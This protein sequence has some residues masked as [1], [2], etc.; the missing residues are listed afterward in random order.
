MFCKTLFCVSAC[1]LL[2]A[3]GVAQSPV[4]CPI[5]SADRSVTICTPVEGGTITSEFKY[6]IYVNDS[7][8]FTY[9][10]Y[11]DNNSTGDQGHWSEGENIYQ[12]VVGESTLAEPGWHKMTIVVFDSQGVFKNTA[13]FRISGEAQCP[14]P[15]MDRTIVVC[16]PVP[17][18]KVQ[19][20]VHIAAVANSTSV[21]ASRTI[22]YVDGV[23][24]DRDYALAPQ[25]PDELGNTISAYVPLALGTHSI[26]IKVVDVN[27]HTF[28]TT[29][30]VEVVSAVSLLPM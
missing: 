2:S 15:T 21:A 17:G 26:Q 16:G 18:A 10:M 5:S 3:V 8:P 23:E 11:L 27:N 28:S 30:S 22:V 9:K 25:I 13:R 29:F 24:V 4:G 14:M 12:I 1:L 7:L 6:H 19:S 20:P